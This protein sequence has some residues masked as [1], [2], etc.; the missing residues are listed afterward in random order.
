MKKR[1]FLFFPAVLIMAVAL[2]TSCTNNWPQYRGPDQNMVANGKNLP[3]Q[4]GESKNI[5]WAVDLDPES[6][7]SPVGQ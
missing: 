2:L 1:N 7:S 4:W 5:R 3:D 6:W